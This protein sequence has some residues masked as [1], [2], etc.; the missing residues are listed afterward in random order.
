MI[1]GV[2]GGLA[3]RLNTDPTLVRLAFAALTLVTGIWIGVAMYLVALVVIPET[4]MEP[5][6]ASSAPEVPVPPAA[7]ATPAS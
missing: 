4:P 2:I 1:G 3:E 7:P 6:P 5:A